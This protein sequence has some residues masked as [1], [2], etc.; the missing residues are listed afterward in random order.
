[1]KTRFL[2]CWCAALAVTPS[3]AAE[4]AFPAGAVAL[5]N[6]Q[7]VARTLLD[8]LMRARTA[9]GAPTSAQDRRRMLD[10]LIDTEIA[11]QRAQASGLAARP[12]IRAEIDLARKTLLGQHLLRQM[13]AEMQIDGATLQAR[14]RDMPPALHIDSTH[15]LVSD[16]N[17]A[18]EL[19]AQLRRGASFATLA[20]KHSIDVAS[21]DHGGALGPLPA[22]ELAAPYVRAVQA[23]KPGQLASEPV[24]TEYGWHVIRLDG[25]RTV[26]KQAFESLKAALRTQIVSERLQAQLTQWKKEAKL[27]VLKAP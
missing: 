19:I 16:E 8:E 2:L 1:M 15:I 11:S 23:L 18:R 24:Q 9:P 27:T 14:Y 4:P 13:A 22:S 20:R 3:H 10:D 12:Q 26:K 25:Q 7:P 6:G 5:V 21:R 17:T